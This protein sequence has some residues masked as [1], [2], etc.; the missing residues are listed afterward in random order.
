M[1]I[2]NYMIENQ[3]V[4]TLTYELYVA[5]EDGGEELFEQ[6][7]VERPLTYCQGEGMMLPAFEAQMAGKEQGDQIDFTIPKE[8]AYGEYD[9]RGLK[10]LPKKLFFDGD[11]EFDAERVFPGNVIPM[12]TTDGMIVK[13]M[14][15]E[16]GDKDVTIDLNHPLAGED[17]HFVGKILEVRD[18]TEGELQ[19]IRNPHRCG[20]C[21]G[22]CDDCESGCGSCEK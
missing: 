14:V 3:K 17:L 18:V 22:K 8:E 10:T 15:L 12:N 20:K 19:A 7:T 21:K 1:K 5:G 6:A 9:E 2:K 4:V 13:A 16:V 11:G